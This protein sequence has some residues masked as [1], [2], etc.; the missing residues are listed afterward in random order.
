MD[1][2]KKKTERGVMSIRFRDDKVS[3]GDLLMVLA[4]WVV[5]GMIFTALGTAA[6]ICVAIDA[7]VSPFSRSTEIQLR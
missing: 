5:V 2:T 4:I 1:V 3:I 6:L 7:C